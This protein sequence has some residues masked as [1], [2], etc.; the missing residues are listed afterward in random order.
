MDHLLTPQATPGAA[1]DTGEPRFRALV[2]NISDAIALLD[3]D[4]TI[5]YSG[6]STMRILGYDIG[7]NVGRNA[8]LLV[9]PEDRP[10]AQ[11]RFHTLLASPGSSGPIAYRLLHRDGSW[12]HME[13]IARN[14][15]DEP[16]VRA[17]V[18]T[19]RDV[20]QRI[21]AEAALR[22]SEERY[23]SVIAALDEG[24]IVQDSDGTITA[25]NESACRIFGVT[26][27]E[28]IGRNVRDCRFRV[29]HEDGSRFPLE[30]Y[31]A[32]VAI[33]TGQPQTRVIMGI[34]CDAGTSVWLSINA[35]PLFRDGVPR[36]YAAVTS[37]T[38]ITERKR[39]EAQLVRA[40]QY[41][42][43][44]G[45]PNRGLFMERLKDA[46]AR[47]KRGKP[48][49]FA[50]LFLDFDHFKAVN[51]SLGH[52]AGDDV[53]VAIAGRLERS[54]R[55]A[56][57]VA[58]LGG[59]EFAILAGRMD[60]PVAATAA[61]LR[62]HHMLAAPFTTRGY[63]VHLT[64]SIGVALSRP[65]YRDAEEMLHDADAAMYRAKNDGDGRYAVADTKGRHP[66][67]NGERPAF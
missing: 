33:E 10:G 60:D 5:V 28:L 14:L 18:V 53:L 37:F 61:A 44:T 31:P 38:D 40:A 1:R 16:G 7:Q 23:R 36:P 29:V 54:L 65:E 34:E 6:P 43:L 45:L 39:V 46:F 12:L 13:G 57:S 58:R 55:P 49:E 15:L 30:H 42:T 47:A 27:G 24:I 25:A 35:H 64:A 32:M 41:D 26:G 63:D 11:A 66:G 59:D 21:V 3:R 52:A 56:E 50:L 48:H 19:Y 62:L 67:M 51:D 8:F 2:E 17:I 20:T 22:E 9:H 4:G